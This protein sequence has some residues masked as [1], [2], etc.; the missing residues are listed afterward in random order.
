LSSTPFSVAI[1]GR[2]W[3]IPTIQTVHILGLALV[4]TAALILA[5]RFVGVGL[6]SEPLAQ[7]ARRYTRLIWILLLVLLA[8]GVLLI[9]AEPGRTI[10]NPVFYLKMC[11]LATVIL[12][13]LWLASAARRYGDSPPGLHKLLAGITLVLWIGIIFCGRFI[14]YFEST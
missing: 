6:T 8:S 5:L 11:L 13:T 14:A 12:V 4:L 10:T 7:L 9:V 2:S 1:Q 3:A